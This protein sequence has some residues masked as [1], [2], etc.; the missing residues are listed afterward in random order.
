MASMTTPIA[1]DSSSLDRN[2][3]APTSPGMSKV[4]ALLDGRSARFSFG[5]WLNF[6]LMLLI[7][8][9]VAAVILA[10]VN[11]IQ[12]AAGRW[13]YRFEML[14]VVVFT[15]EYML[16]L[17]SA[18]ELPRYRHLSASRARWRYLTSGM[19]IIDLIAIAPFYFSIFFTLDL[20][21]VRVLRLLRI[22]K[23][24]RHSRALQILGTVL[25]R[26]SGS[27]LAAF[28][29]LFVLLILASSGI[30]LIESTLQPD[31][32]GSIPEAMWWAM[33][34][35]TTVGYG[36]VTPITSWGKFF[37]SMVTIIGMGMVALPAG[38]L[39]SGFAEQL[40]QRR[41]NFRMVVEALLK[42]AEAGD[43]NALLIERLRVALQIDHD[44][45]QRIITAL[46]PR[47][48]NTY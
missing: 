18:P 35:L 11:W 21:F 8:L 36:D 47:D 12:A 9:N 25:R 15:I 29:V 45:A 20:R 5:Y 19:A 41:D 28:S 33:A 16:R 23:F 13:F 32:F 31:K 38:I 10:S 46:Q 26:E 39:A 22:F 37:G 24:T 7:I 30:Y 48:T 3:P 6:G 1:P 27:L 4:A 44:T 17:W 40:A 14:S 43:D 2:S 42:R 34:T